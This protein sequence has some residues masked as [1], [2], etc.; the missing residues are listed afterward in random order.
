MRVVDKHMKFN[1]LP[2]RYFLYNCSERKIIYFNYLCLYFY[3]FMFYAL[4]KYVHLVFFF[5]D[6][7]NSLYNLISIVFFFYC[8]YF[9]LFFGQRFTHLQSPSF[10]FHHRYHSVLGFYCYIVDI[11]LFILCWSKVQPHLQS[12][13]FQFHHRYHSMLVFLRFFFQFQL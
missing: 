1:S 7:W 8:W 13:S 5:F 6:F 12:P 9:F 11:F 10:Q 4:R 2:R 3:E